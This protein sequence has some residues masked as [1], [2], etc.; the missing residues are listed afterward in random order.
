[1]R[2]NRII[3][4]HIESIIDHETGE[5]KQSIRNESRRV[6]QEPDYV[7]LYL[8][9][10]QLLHGI[11][12]SAVLNELLKDLGYS[13]VLYTFKPVIDRIQ[14]ATSLKYDTIKKTIKKYENAGILIN[15]GRCE[16]QVNPN[17]F[18][19]GRWTDIQQIRLIVDY[20]KDGKLLR[21]EINKLGLDE[22]KK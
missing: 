22:I 1:M 14:A 6:Q 2:E 11:P 8:S 7:K 10:I 20:N 4:Q 3:N 16:H 18:A 12:N 21:A 9:D 15:T 19:R 13:G 5:L 17:L